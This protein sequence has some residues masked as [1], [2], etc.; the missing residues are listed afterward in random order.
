[1]C[2][3]MC[4]YVLHMFICMYMCVSVLYSRFK[5]QLLLHSL[6]FRGKIGWPGAANDMV[7]C[8]LL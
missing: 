6:K 5:L 2:I 4:V 8:L 1:M 7:N 3:C